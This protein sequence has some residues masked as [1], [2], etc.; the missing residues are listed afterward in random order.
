MNAD[1]ANTINVNPLLSQKMCAALAN[2]ALPT[3]Y[4]Q[5]LK[6][7]AY[8]LLKP[9]YNIVTTIL[10]LCYNDIT[11]LLLLYLYG[12]TTLLQPYFYGITTL[13]PPYYYCITTVFQP[14]F[15]E[16]LVNLHH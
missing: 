14:H 12:I 9:H 3:P 15:N 10:P 5:Y 16:I 4:F 1:V 13:L 11:T 2:S 8:H 7:K 6:A